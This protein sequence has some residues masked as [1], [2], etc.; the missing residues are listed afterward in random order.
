M[1]GNLETL[2]F[3]ADSM[4]GKL[5]KWLRIMGCDT[6]YQ[7]FYH[8]E[9]LGRLI[10]GGRRLLT[11]HRETF[12]HY[13]KALLIR[14]D[15]VGE[16]LLEMTVDGHLF[17]DKSKWFSRCLVCNT[18][19]EGVEVDTAR[20]DIPEYVFYN[21]ISDIMSCPSCN[22]YFWPGSHRQRMVRQ[23]ENWGF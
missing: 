7:A 12:G 3:I 9:T 11:R 15:H 8:G 21:N 10:N 16:Q 4:L 20:E 1:E 22:R 6:H 2:R 13:P 17:I 18:P 19:L 14:S 5:A 23:L